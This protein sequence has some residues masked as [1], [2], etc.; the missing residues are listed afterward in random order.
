MF[1]R[2]QANAQLGASRHGAMPRHGQIRLT[3]PSASLALVNVFY[4]QP[5]NTE[6]RA[7]AW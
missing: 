1:A 4:E 3:S 6:I 7:S 2:P 5:A